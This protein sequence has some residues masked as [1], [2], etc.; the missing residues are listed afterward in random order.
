MKG[1]W[2]LGFGDSVAKMAYLVL[3]YMSRV[4]WSGKLVGD[5]QNNDA[6]NMALA[7]S[8]RRYMEINS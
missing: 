6:A 1:K 8:R 3:Q 4:G 5:H 2:K 7:G